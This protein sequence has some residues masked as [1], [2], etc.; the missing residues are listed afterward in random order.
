MKYRTRNT[1]RN[2]FDRIKRVER[3]SIRSSQSLNEGLG[4]GWHMRLEPVHGGPRADPRNKS[5][6]RIQTRATNRENERLAK[7]YGRSLP[8]P[9]GHWMVSLVARSG[10]WRQNPAALPSPRFYPSINRVRIPRVIRNRRCFVSKVRTSRPDLSLTFC[11]RFLLNSF[12]FFGEISSKRKMEK[13]DERM[14]ENG[15][16]CILKIFW[17]VGFV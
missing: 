3:S 11:L 8:K 17:G 4:E 7:I 10:M 9:T 16:V 15:L 2:S 12:F 1:T 6:P 13:T 14:L 5:R